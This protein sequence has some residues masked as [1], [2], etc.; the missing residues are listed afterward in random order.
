M[1]NEYKTCTVCGQ[2]KPVDAYNPDG[3]Y[4]DHRR[5]DCRECQEKAAS[6][7]RSSTAD[8]ALRGGDYNPLA[9]YTPRQL[10]AELRRRGYAGELTVT[11]TIKI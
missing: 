8:K 10:I 5:P 6:L 7:K 1:T 2:V 3:R 4:H 11:Q 9:E